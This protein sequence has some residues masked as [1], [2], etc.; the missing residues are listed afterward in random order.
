MGV[1]GTT[2]VHNEIRRGQ[3]YRL[4][5]LTIPDHHES[6]LTA[7]DHDRVKIVKM[8]V[9]TENGEVFLLGPVTEREGSGSRHRQPGERRENA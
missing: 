9:T 5:A 3:P 7:T 8:K 4:G 6:S 2:E 1:E